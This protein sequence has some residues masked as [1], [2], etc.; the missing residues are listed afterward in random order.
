MKWYDIFLN[1]LLPGVTYKRDKD[2]AQA[3]QM[4]QAQSQ[5]SGSVSSGFT[6]PIDD[7]YMKMIEKWKGTDYYD[8]FLNNPYLYQNN[9]DFTPTFM[10]SLGEQIFGDY[11]ARNNYY[12]QLK[13]QANQYYAQGIENMRQDKFNSPTAQASR[14]RS[15]GL[16][17]DLAGGVSGVAGAAD[18]DVFAPKPMDMNPAAVG[19]SALQELGSTLVQAFS[20]GMS[21]VQTMQGIKSVSLDNQSKEVGLLSGVNSLANTFI[22]ENMSAN[23]LDSDSP[24]VF[25]DQMRKLVQG[26]GRDAFHSRKLANIFAKNVERNYSSL[27]G[28]S[29]RFKGVKDYSDSRFEAGKSLGRN[30][31]YGDDSNDV[32]NL[33]AFRKISSI[34]ADSELKILKMSNRAD[35]AEESNRAVY[36]E[37]LD[38]GAQAEAANTGAEATT[39]S[40]KAA[41]SMNS[42]RKVVNDTAYRVIDVLDDSSKQGGVAGALSSA[43]LMVVFGMMNNITPSLP[44]VSFSKSTGSKGSKFNFSIH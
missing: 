10:Q 36:N 34:L 23:L 9:L 25:D 41:K 35:L 28:Y 42:I 29:R 24:I 38:P 26:Y 21:M 19:S 33:T 43:A 32:F 13:T 2:Q 20:F 12:E 11:S 14:A 7:D 27:R 6:K 15:A 17:P 18:N 3:F 22:D 4:M 8:Y 30:D 39:E 5:G 40:N 44:G 37:Q 16:N 1:M 31:A